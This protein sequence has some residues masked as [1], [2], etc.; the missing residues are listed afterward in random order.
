[1]ILTTPID[2]KEINEYI[3]KETRCSIEY[4]KTNICK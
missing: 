3:A 1:S 4:L 2:Y